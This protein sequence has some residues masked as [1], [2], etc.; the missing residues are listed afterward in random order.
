[1]YAG[2]SHLKR[3]QELNRWEY[4]GRHITTESYWCHPSS[5]CPRSQMN[6]HG[7]THLLCAE[8]PRQTPM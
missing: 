6:A 5:S 3:F 2:I 7:G 8:Q 4:A 1:M